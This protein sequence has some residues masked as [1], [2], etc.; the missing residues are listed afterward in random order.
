MNEVTTITLI[1]CI[2]QHKD[3]KKTHTCTCKNPIMLTF[4]NILP[5]SNRQ[6][7]IVTYHRATDE[8]ASSKSH[9]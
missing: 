7:M 1:L 8:Q 6:V 3:T 5:T 9:M 2:S 4:Q